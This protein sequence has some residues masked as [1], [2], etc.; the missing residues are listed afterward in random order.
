MTAFICA[1][2]ELTPDVNLY[3][4]A[5]HRL[6]NLGAVVTHVMNGDIATRASTPSGAC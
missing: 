3:I 4:E 6:S 1:T 2:L 5:V